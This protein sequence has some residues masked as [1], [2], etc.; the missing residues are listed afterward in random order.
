VVQD[1]EVSIQIK[2]QGGLKW[3]GTR[4]RANDAAS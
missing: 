2:D 3:G 1:G 4:P